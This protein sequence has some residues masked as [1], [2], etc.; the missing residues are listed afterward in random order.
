[1]K[2]SKT[3]FVANILATFY[4]LYLLWLYGGMIAVIINA[5]A[6]LGGADF[7]NA[8]GA[9]LELLGASFKLIFD[10]LGIASPA[11]NFLYTL[12]A[13]L[14][15]HIV[16]FILGCIIGWI[17]YFRKESGAAKFAATFYL[18]GTI[19]YPLHLFLSLPIVIIGFIG[20]GQQK[21]LNMAV[22][23]EA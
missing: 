19:C 12:F 16:V 14:C 5:F 18:I 9:Y 15:V 11:A 2:R 7:A 1:M 13:M 20:G 17:A 23:S 10:I 6:E 22:I 8:I 21:K 4:I 3:L